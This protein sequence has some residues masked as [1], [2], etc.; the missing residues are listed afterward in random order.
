MLLF[1]CGNAVTGY[2]KTKTHNWMEIF[3]EERQVTWVYVIAQ[4]CEE[5]VQVTRRAQKD[6]CDPNTDSTGRSLSPVTGPSTQANLRPPLCFDFCN[7]INDR[8]N[9]F[10]FVTVQETC[11]F[12]KKLFGIKIHFKTITY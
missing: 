12:K 9:D 2:I 4:C 11:I 7:V 1:V 3:A 6:G 10:H 5:F 8:K